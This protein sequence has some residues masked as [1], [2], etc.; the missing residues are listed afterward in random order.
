[1]MKGSTKMK[2]V[3]SFIL[4]AVIL[5]TVFYPV[6]AIEMPD[7]E[8][9]KISITTENGN[10]TSLQKADGYIN[11][12]VDISDNEGFSLSD[13]IV[14]KVRGN[15]TARI[16][17]QKKSYTIKFGK[18]KD[19]FSMGSGKKW[20]LI[21]NVLDPTLAR[22]YTAF[23]I[24][25]QLGIRYTSDF[26][27]VELW[28]DDSFRGCYLLMEPV[29]EGK[30]RVNIDVE[31]ND[32]KKDFLLELEK[33]RTEE[34][35]TYIKSDGIRFAINE[36]EEVD[37]DQVSY[38]QGVVDNTI[39]TIK[40]GS[41]EEIESKVDIDS[42]V[43]F[44][45][46]NEF[47]KPVDL[48]Y[49]SVFFYY[50]D[51]KFCA[52]PPWDYDLSTGNENKDDSANYADANKTD[53][54]YAN[55]NF[56]KY[57]CKKDWFNEKVK[58]LFNEQYPYFR[59]IYSADGVIDSFYKTY[60]LAIKRNYTPGVWLVS[61]CWH[62]I[63]KE[64]LSS[65]KENYDYYVNWCKERVEWLA[66]Y[67]EV[68]T[69]PYNDST[70]DET[71]TEA[72]TETATEPQSTEL[73]TY[74]EIKSETKAETEAETEPGT[75]PYTEAVTATEYITEPETVPAT[76][77]APP[78]SPSIPFETIEPPTEISTEVPT[79]EP[80][81]APTVATEPYET[82]AVTETIPEITDTSEVPQPTSPISTNPPE[83]KAEDIETQ[84]PPT[85][86]ETNP[87][88]VSVNTD[89][90]E[91]SVVPSLKVSSVNL[92]AGKTAAITVLNKGNNKVTYKSTNKKVA[93]VKNRKA[94]A[95]KNGTADII[96]TVGNTK[97]TY[98]VKVTS[99]PKLSR[100]N[101]TVKEGKTKTVK[102]KGKSEFVKNKYKN[103]EYAKIISK[104]SA[105]KIK[106]K[107]LKKGKTTLKITVNG[108]KLKLKVKV[109]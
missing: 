53:G 25:Q 56:F 57:L 63:Q 26:K 40:T 62:S 23:S 107:G 104:K 15:S 11:A 33:T 71:A 105:K 48:N 52:G 9:P 46:L 43:K 1:M 29:A 42:F 95:L 19:L 84:V 76:E 72:V 41:Y 60:E 32:G 20:A 34:D 54:I 96:V 79:E 36:P 59:S 10:G 44:Y 81:D 106:I 22:N 7:S 61:K 31:G 47:L 21:S 74:S 14:M 69:S 5:A 86:P 77:T 37:E 83:T 28:L 97:L 102:I 101:I 78:V 91:K 17:I 30:D 70:P 75:E 85:Q 65:Y 12:Q 80:T 88:P 108:V 51:G 66:Q 90:S 24:A 50:Q 94:A 18:K 6:Y 100:K 49:S 4:A 16:A 73:N 67:F 58:E 8:F 68:D 93:I 55:K 98:K 109:K 38:I 103:S 13:S 3:I 89:P 2:K 82:E 39:S 45:L 35:K 87:Q 27:V 92:K 64:P 99:S